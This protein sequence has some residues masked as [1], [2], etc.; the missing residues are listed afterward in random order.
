VAQ[1]ERET[2][3][4][5]AREDLPEKGREKAKVEKKEPVGRLFSIKTI[6]HLRRRR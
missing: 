5:R 2:E 3:E 6:N 4:D 1:K